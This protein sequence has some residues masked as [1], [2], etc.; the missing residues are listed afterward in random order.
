MTSNTE[1]QALIAQYEADMAGSEIYELEGQIA[2]DWAD[3]LAAALSALSSLAETETEWEYGIGYEGNNGVEVK[4][5]SLYDRAFTI[6][7]A[8][9]RD[10]QLYTTDANVKLVRRRKAAPWIEVI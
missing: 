6:R 7:E 8:A 5:F 3:K 10:L 9:E 2:R 1:V 4:W